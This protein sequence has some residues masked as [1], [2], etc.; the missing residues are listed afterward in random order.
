MLENETTPEQRADARYKL[1]ARRASS[2]QKS[3]MNSMLRMNLGNAKT[4]FVIFH[5]GIPKLLQSNSEQ[6]TEPEPAE[7]LAAFIKW[8]ASLLISLVEHSNNGDAE[9]NRQVSKADSD[10]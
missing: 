10:A 9:Y 6:A 8:H 4:A 3:W 1:K 7:L 2:A 5:P